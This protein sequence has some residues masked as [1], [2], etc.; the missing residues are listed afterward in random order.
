[1]HK[2]LTPRQTN[3]RLKTDAENGYNDYLNRGELPSWKKLQ[4]HTGRI[5]TMIKEEKESLRQQLKEEAW[6]ELEKE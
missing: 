2:V 4:L 6:K 5:A 3:Y 1:M